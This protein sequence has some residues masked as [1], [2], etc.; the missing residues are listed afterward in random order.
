[1]LPNFR[2]FFFF[3]PF[4][5][6]RSAE[7]EKMQH[8]RF[9]TW[10]ACTNSDTEL[11]LMAA[12]ANWS[13]RCFIVNAKRGLFVCHV[14]QCISHLS[15]RHVCSLWFKLQIQ[16][17]ENMVPQ[18]WL[19]P[20]AWCVMVVLGEGM[21]DVYY[22]QIFWCIEGQF[23]S[24]QRLLSNHPAHIRFLWLFTFACYNW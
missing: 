3:A 10:L 22:M 8:G 11:D 24:L 6:L 18:S 9:Q 19:S 1:M 4:S 15:Q 17:W 13:Y 2:F 12:L 21:C 7:K 14:N 20:A 16:P 23:F 5:K